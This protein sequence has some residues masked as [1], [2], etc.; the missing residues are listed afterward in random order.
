M[1]LPV[2]YNYRHTYLEQAQK[3]IPLTI[4]MSNNG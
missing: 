3:I 2:N 1:L 4:Q